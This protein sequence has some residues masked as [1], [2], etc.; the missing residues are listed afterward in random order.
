[1]RVIRIAANV[2]GLQTHYTRS[3]MT[4]VSLAIF[5]SENGGK[6]LAEAFHAN[7][8]GSRIFLETQGQTP[9]RA[10][11]RQEIAGLINNAIESANM[12]DECQYCMEA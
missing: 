3:L 5:A 11:D 4:C 8:G 9:A 2:K 1:M 10:V 12:D 7:P 6:E